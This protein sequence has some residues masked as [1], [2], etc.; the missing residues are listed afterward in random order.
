MG[1]RY[2]CGGYRW[3]CGYFVILMGVI[4]KL[5]LFPT[6]PFSNIFKI[7]RRIR[8]YKV[9][10]DIIIQHFLKEDIGVTENYS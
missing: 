8:Q 9:H 3:I 4:V 10:L 6:C 7:I 5:S 1:N 2:L